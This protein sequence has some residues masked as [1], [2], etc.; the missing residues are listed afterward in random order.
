MVA[1]GDGG[2]GLGGSRQN[3]QSKRNQGGAKKHVPTLREKLPGNSG[4]VLRLA[5][6]GGDRQPGFFPQFPPVFH[7]NATNCQQGESELGRLNGR[8]TDCGR[9]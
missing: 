5:E 3:G 7:S 1:G 4:R 2:L 6:G 9:P 8:V